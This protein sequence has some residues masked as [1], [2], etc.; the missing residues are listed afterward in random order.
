MNSLQYNFSIS[1]IF[2][3]SMG[4][5]G[6]G[7]LCSVKESLVEQLGRPLSGSRRFV[8]FRDSED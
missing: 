3:S 4:E 8:N 6:S 7:L 5:R 1:A 2:A